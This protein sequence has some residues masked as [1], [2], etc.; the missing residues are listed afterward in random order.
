MELKKITKKKVI[1]KKPSISKKVSKIGIFKSS[2]RTFYKTKQLADSKRVKGDRIYYNT[3]EKAY[4]IR[5][6]KKYSLF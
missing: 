4:Y 1:T 2:A 3:S 5:R 6:P